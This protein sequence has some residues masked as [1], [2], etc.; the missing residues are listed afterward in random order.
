MDGGKM[1]TQDQSIEL[2]TELGAEL[3][4]RGVRGAFFGDDGA[5]LSVAFNTRRLT[6]D[7]TAVFEPTN[8]ISETARVV[9]RR[10]GRLSDAWVN[11][12][13]KGLFPETE[14]A[15]QV[16]LE[17][18]GLSVCVPTPEYVLAL[19]NHASRV[20]RNADD[21]KFLEDF[22]VPRAKNN[23]DVAIRGYPRT[24]T[25]PKAPAALANALRSVEENE[26]VRFT[27][28]WISEA[29]NVDDEPDL[30]GNDVVDAVVSA[31]SALVGM[32][33]NGNEPEWTTRPGR[34]LRS[35][36]WHPGNPRMFAY[37]LV[38]APAS[39]AIRG[40]VIEKD[41]LASV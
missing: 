29:G 15:Q 20:D 36:L 31:A 34:G 5:V 38:H 33:R 18:P 35:R 40:V 32:R 2:L 22:L 3:A 9:S 23:I 25:S 8:V 4:S 30:T 26:Y 13:V 11:D 10:R 39:F 27:A 6:T 24:A 7:V 1:L 41:S 28:H 19:K 17:V 37:S 16:V 21:I 12:V 14:P